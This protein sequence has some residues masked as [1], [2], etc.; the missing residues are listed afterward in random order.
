VPN[1][2]VYSVRRQANIFTNVSQTQVTDYIPYSSLRNDTLY[3]RATG[4][5]VDLT[6]VF[7]FFPAAKRSYTIVFKGRYQTTG[8]T[9]IARLLTSFT[10]Y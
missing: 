6:P 7:S 4:T 5:T 10:D 2:D 3:V 8:T 9:G 1:V